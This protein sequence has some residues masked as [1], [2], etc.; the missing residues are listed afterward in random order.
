MTRQITIDI[1][2]SLSKKDWDYLKNFAKRVEE[3]SKIKLLS[4]EQGTI[5]AKIKYERGK[6]LSLEA[7]LPSDEIISE[8]LMAF[9]LF[10]LQKEPTYFPRIIN[11]IN[12]HITL[13]EANNLLNSYKKRWEDNLFNQALF[14]SV[15]DEKLSSSKILDLWFNAHYFHSDEEK[16]RELH[17]INSILSEPFSKYMLLTSIFESVKIIFKVYDSLKPILSKEKVENK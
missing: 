14:I 11:I 3:L 13:P 12:K 7:S 9:R 5:Q 16:S 8:L 6:G 10:Y 15:N 17:K 4:S 2:G 1:S